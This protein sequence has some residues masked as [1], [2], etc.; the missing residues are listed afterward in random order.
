MSDEETGMGPSVL[1][2]VLVTGSRRNRTRAMGRVALFD[3]EGNAI[4]LAAGSQGPKGDPG[5]VGPQGS[6]G[7]KGDKGDK[8]DQGLAGVAGPKGDQGVQGVVGPQGA[9]GDQG[10]KGDTGVGVAGP[11]GPQGATG[12]AGTQGPAGA[13][14]PKGD[15][16]SQGPQGLQGLQ[17][18]QGIKGDNGPQGSI[19]AT[20]PAGAQGAQGPS[21]VEGPKGDPGDDAILWRGKI[22]CTG[23]TYRAASFNGTVAYHVLEVTAVMGAPSLILAIPAQAEAFELECTHQNTLIRKDDAAYHYLY[24]GM[25]LIPNDEDGLSTALVSSMQH[26]GVN[27]FVGFNTKR[28][29]RCKAG[30]AY[31]IQAIMGGGNGGTWNYVKSSDTFLEAK[32]LRL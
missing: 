10:V 32:A 25:R 18:I 15:T 28:T 7:V 3:A 17:G 8:G 6:Q 13:G 26:S 21:G 16:G 23:G 5:P 12:A 20:G 22:W 4:D 2:A 29:F 31:Q 24:T 9:K 30:T 11:A 14:G 27:Q 1:D 19:G